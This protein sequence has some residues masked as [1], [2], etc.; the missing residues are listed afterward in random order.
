M[1]LHFQTELSSFLFQ[2]LLQEIPFDRPLFQLKS[3]FKEHSLLILEVND[4]AFSV[5]GMRG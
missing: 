1:V 3:F 5:F 4:K 2:L